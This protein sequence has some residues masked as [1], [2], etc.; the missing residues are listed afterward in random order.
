ME[1]RCHWIGF[2]FGEEGFC[3]S[4]FVLGVEESRGLVPKR[5]NPERKGLI[6]VGMGIDNGLATS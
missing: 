2:M 3:L 5:Q 1:G 6:D 4:P